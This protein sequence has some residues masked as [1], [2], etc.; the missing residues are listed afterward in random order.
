MRIRNAA[1]AGATAI[2]VAFGGTTIASAEE[3]SSLSSESGTADS[4]PTLSSKIADSGLVDHGEGNDKNTQFTGQDI[5]GSSKNFDNVPDWAQGFYALTVVA[6]IGSIIGL[7]V[8]PLANY[9]QFGQ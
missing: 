8:G 9:I 5:F 1:I 7:V 4:A 3:G 6:S 2:A